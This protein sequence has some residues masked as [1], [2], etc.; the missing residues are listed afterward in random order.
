M[1]ERFQYGKIFLD[2]YLQSKRQKLEQEQFAEEVRLKERNL[3][4]MEKYYDSNTE[5]NKAMEKDALADNA[6]ALTDQ[7]INALGSFA[8]VTGNKAFEGRGFQGGELNKGIFGAGENFLFRDP[9]KYVTQNEFENYQRQRASRPPQPHFVE[10]KT[11][12]NPTFDDTGENITK[13]GLITRVYG[14]NYNKQT[15]ELSLDEGGF[16]EDI[17]RIAGKKPAGLITGM[18]RKW[19]TNDGKGGGKS[20]T[21]EQFA[22]ELVKNQQNSNISDE[23]IAE[24]HNSY[25]MDFYPKYY[26][27]Q[28]TQKTNVAA[29]K[30]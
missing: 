19:I 26:R 20:P 14:D 15:V 21:P 8:D 24:I 13:P 9:N 6:R 1:A 29:T 27:Y 5:H 23:Q 30:K 16:A 3:N 12:D 2:A 22:D 17:Y 7:K 10:E 4:M 11:I 28:K 18:L 25:M